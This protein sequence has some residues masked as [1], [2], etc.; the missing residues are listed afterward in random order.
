MRAIIGSDPLTYVDC[1]ARAGKL[2]SAFRAVEDSHYIGFEADAAE[3]ARMNALAVNHARYVCAFLGRRREPRTFH[4]TA[5]PACSS[6]LAP[7]LPFL[8]SF[9]DLRSAF[10]VQQR[11]TVDTAPLDGA[12]RAEGITRIDVLELDTQ[13]TEL[14]I[15]EGASDLVARSVLAVKVEVEFSPLY[16][17]QPLFADVDAFMRGRDFQLFDMSRYRVRREGLKT[18]VPTRGQLLWGHALYLRDCRALP[19]H[20]AARLA[21]VAALMDVPDYAYQILTNV[22]AAPDAE[23]LHA[24]ARLLIA[25]LSRAAETPQALATSID[26]AQWRD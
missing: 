23:P 4:V 21:A 18:S 22:A 19:S 11:I 20:A 8:S 2:P 12:L 14:E 17:G 3:C 7:N 16:E 15:L 26:R 5:S 24:D 25:E 13:G 1:G 9:V 10:E 6:L